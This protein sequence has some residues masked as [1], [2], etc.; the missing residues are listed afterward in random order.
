MQVEVIPISELKPLENNPRHHSATQIEK[1]KESIERF[2]FTNP[3][4]VHKDSTI[5]AGHGRVEAAKEAG[6]DTVP[7]I[8]LDMDKAD[9]LLYALADNRLSDLSRWDDD[10][11]EEMAKELSE[12]DMNL[13]DAGFRIDEI[14]KLIGDGVEEDALLQS[15]DVQ[16]LCE[17]GDIWHLGPH[18]VICAD[19][20]DPSAVERLLGDDKPNLMVTDPPYGVEYEPEW[21]KKMLDTTTKRIGKVQ[22]DDRWDW[23]LTYELFSGN[24]IYLWH[25]GWSSAHFHFEGEQALGAGAGK[26]SRF[27]T[28]H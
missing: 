19:S 9:A 10:K 28:F 27:E 12:L 25:A 11:L 16:S 8:F 22:N 2:G 21:R 24:I 26:A 18:R 6:H 7:V 23:S 3:I 13:E 4:L 14:D 17:P 20:C 5:I 15:D 1:L